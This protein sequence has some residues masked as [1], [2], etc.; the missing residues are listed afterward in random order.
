MPHNK[1]TVVGGSGFIGT[2]LVLRL[3]KNT[4]HLVSVYDK[5]LF[6]K[7]KDITVI[8]DILDRNSLLES[9][10]EGSIVV[11]L[12]AEHKDD[13]RPLSKYYDVN[14][15]G[16][17]NIC[18]AARLKNVNKIIFTSSVA[19]YGFA[20]IGTDELGTI[21]PFN[22]Y[23]RTKFAAEQI[24]KEWQSEQPED[25]SL[26]IIRPTVVFG[27]RNRGNVYNLL[28]Q[29]VSGRFLMVGN[30][31]NRKSMAY[32]E[33]LCAFLEHC[34]VFKSGVY[35]YNYVDKPDFTMNSLVSTINKSIGKKSC[36]KIHL[37]YWFGVTVGHA[38][39]LISSITKKRFAI[40]SIRI[41]KFCTDSVYNTA[42][43]ETGFVPP[44]PLLQALDQTLRYEFIESH[45]C[46]EVFYTD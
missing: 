4:N 43:D 44:V 42:V 33:N 37:P 5:K 46:D 17:R 39:D 12:A 38:F 27:E 22:E 13:V 45:T 31:K 34:L 30:G 3:I 14:V 2:R 29:I 32:V 9:I 40:S 6:N 25:R 23:G 18:S 26:I 35:V 7:F 28:K 15:D 36:Y 11:N 19:V 21:A 8:G 24:Y 16:A 10:P 1:I 20:K 41:K